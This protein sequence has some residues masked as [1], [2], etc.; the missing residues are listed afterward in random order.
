MEI[1]LILTHKHPNYFLYQNKKIVED[2]IKF[3]IFSKQILKIFGGDK[4]VVNVHFC[5][6]TQMQ[7]S[8]FKYRL[9][10]ASFN[11]FLSQISYPFLFPKMLFA[12]LSNGGTRKVCVSGKAIVKY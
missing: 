3:P 9:I 10:R 1:G 2:V 12:R 11:L 7:H 5:K 6:A 8:Y 4:R